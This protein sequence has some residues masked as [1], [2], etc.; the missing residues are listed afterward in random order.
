[1]IDSSIEIINSSYTLKFDYNNNYV[2][3]I[4]T[5]LLK[6]SSIN[7]ISIAI[8]ASSSLSIILLLSLSL[9][10]SSR[11]CSI[12][13]K[14]LAETIVYDNSITSNSLQSSQIDY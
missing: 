5:K 7:V 8:L 3:I 1:M 14:T 2:I 6:S 4:L 10:D 11:Y 13:S 12:I 9:E